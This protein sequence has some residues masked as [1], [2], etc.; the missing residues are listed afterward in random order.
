[1]RLFRSAFAILCVVMGIMPLAAAQT[2]LATGKPVF[3]TGPTYPGYPASNLTDGTAETFAHP[4][5]PSNTLGFYFQ[6]DLGATQEL[7]RI[8]LTGRGDGCCVERLSRYQ[9]ELRADNNGQPG[10][11]NWMGIMRSD[12]SHP[13]VGGSDTILPADGS[14]SFAGRFLRIVNV[15]DDQFNPQIAEVAAYGTPGPKI[16]YF[17]ASAGNISATGNPGLPTQTT[18]SW[19]VDNTTSLS[20]S[21]T[22][23]VVPGPSGSFIVAPATATTYTLTATRGAASV[24]S[25]ATI[26][27]DAFFTPPRINEIAASNDGSFEDENGEDSDWIEIRNPN[28]YSL[29]LKGAHLTDRSNQPQ[30]W[31]FPDAMVP[32]NGYLVVFASSKDRAEKGSELHTNFSLSDEGEYLGLNAPGGSPAW[33]EFAP[34]FPAQKEGVGY[35]Y[36]GSGP[37][38]YLTPATP[39]A[40]NPATAKTG[41]VAEPVFSKRRG[42]YSSA[43]GVT[44]SCATAGA[45]I[46]YTTNGTQPTESNGSTFTTPL[47]LSN[48]TILRAAAFAPNFVPSRVE[49]NTYIFP[50]GVIAS[51]VMRTSITQNPTY[52]PE[53][54]AALLDLPSMSLVAPGPLDGDIE[55]A[56]SIEFLDPALTTNGGLPTIVAPAANAGVKYFGGA[57]TDFEKKNFRLAFRGIYGDGKLNGNLFP[58]RKDG[59]LPADSFDSIELRSG[60][61]DMWMRGFYLSN[62]FTDDIVGEMGSMQAHGRMVHLYLNGVYHGVY[63]LRER[64]GAAMASSYLG[65]D[66]ADYESINGNLN[67]G[68]WA[69]GS[70]YDGDGTAWERIKAMR[71]DYPSIAKYVDVDN[72]LDYMI[73]WMFGNAENEYRTTGPWREDGGSGFKFMLNDADGWLSVNESNQVAAWDGSQNNTAR[74]GS[75]PGRDNGDGP[76]SL[77]SAWLQSG[78]NDF[79][80][81]FADRIH[82]HLGPGGALS[83]ERNAA[84]LTTMANAFARPHLAESARWNFRTPDG[85]NGARDVCLNQWLPTRTQTVLTQFR[86]AGFVPNTSAP[87]LTPTSGLLASGSVSLSGTATIFYTKDGSDPRLPG[88]A[89]NPTALAAISGSS[90]AITKPTR[91]KLRSRA[92]GGEWSALT[93]AFFLPPGGNALPAGSVLA[94]ELNYQPTGEGNG[95]FIELANIST[96]AVNL[97]G[98]SF[99]SGIQFAF[100]SWRD[101]ILEPGQRLV[102]ADS[103]FSF[104]GL[105]GWDEP[106]AGVYRGNL[107]ND[108]EELT[109]N[110]ASGSP[111][112]DFS[113]DAAWSEQASGGGKT[114]I[115]LPPR[116]GMDLSAAAS[117]ATSLT[118]GGEPNTSEWQTFSG[119]AS[120]FTHYALAGSGPLH[121]PEMIQ[122]PEGPVV[123]IFRNVLA[124]DADVEIETSTDLAQWGA[125]T[126]AS[127]LEEETIQGIRRQDWLLPANSRARFVRLKVTPR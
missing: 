51:S 70:F 79:K 56:A 120:D 14:G 117:W 111:V 59:W 49:T 105:H 1:M 88:G 42:F 11:V 52:G 58:D 7:E 126:G 104:R 43:Q 15:S 45:T 29:N 37:L 77:L 85:W 21:P 107:S 22:V 66:K 71:S 87:A 13:P 90:I 74:A 80:I 50:A 91:L 103:D 48:T 100:S 83:P 127:L 53:M 75:I 18:L 25:T 69:E 123:R 8:V 89:Q 121:L 122:A 73:M 4:N 12:G 17:G 114:L 94:T 55:T 102:L 108:G 125:L 116:P 26:G 64:W 62:P 60:S 124:A 3:A 38:G 40:A 118:T 6:I 9:V 63:H 27:V 78:G 96:Q 31:T 54:S 33:S 119:S 95:E 112:L 99:S 30:R 2:N 97:R 101:T 67:V 32:P 113:Y 109:L 16:R 61:H 44:L 34:S 84:R 76:A 10:A 41:F 82:R 47:S 36:P 5:L 57:F 65:G 24:Q 106:I 20:I 35:G 86:N 93:E 39:G 81:R 23:G 92:A 98:A 115:L 28:T 46:R 110:D 72:Y 68:G 19:I